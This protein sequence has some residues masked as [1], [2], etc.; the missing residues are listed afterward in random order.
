M[1]LPARATPGNHVGHYE[2]LCEVGAGGMGVV[3]KAFDH[4]LQ[5][6]VALKFLPPDPIRNPADR[7]RLLHEAR[8]A[9]TL[10]HKNIAAIHAVEEAGDGQLFIVMAYYEGMS[11]ATRMR[12]TPL[13]KA[14]SVDIV[15]QIAEGLEHAHLHNIVHRDIKPSNVI[16]TPEGEAKIVDFGLARFVSAGAS[17]ETLSLAGT[18]SY[19]SP[20]QLSG[21]PVDARTDVWSLGVIAYELLTNRMPFE[22]DNPAATITAILQSPPAEME[23]VSPELQ[24]IVLRALS[25][26]V[27]DRYQSCGELVRDLKTVDTV[28]GDPTHSV[29]REIF[30]V[31]VPLALSPPADRGPVL[32]RKRRW[33]AAIVVTLLAL[34]AGVWIGKRIIDWVKE[35]QVSGTASPAAYETY[36][37]GL[38][39]LRRYDK[40]GNLDAAIRLFETTTKADPKFALAFAALGEA[41]WD[42]Y[43]REGDPRWVELAS[44]SCRRAAELNDRLPAVFVTLGRIHDGT[45]QHNLA[46]QEFE[47]ALELDH[48][49]AD[50]LLGLGDAYSR[51]GRAQE[52]EDTYKRAA[53]MR[54]EYWDGHYRLG[55]FY[56]QQGRFPDA[57]SQFRRVVELLPDHAPAHTSL[58]TAWLSLGQ[59]RDAEAE[60]KKS[61]ALAPDYPALANLGVMYYRQKR[62]AES[63]AMTERALSLND[64]DYRLWNNLAIAYEWLGQP[65]KAKDAF[66]RELAR[67]EQIVALKSEDAEVR[68]NLG[69]MY[70]QQHQRDRALPHL[71]AAL[72]LS[73]DDPEI[74]NKVGEA[75]EKLGER[76]KGLEYFQ[77]A[78]RKGLT[79]EDMEMN[80]DLR[81]LLSDPSARRLL[82][83]ALPPTAKLQPSANR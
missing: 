63:T 34:I 72:A 65:E 49:D 26:S 66:S 7:K 13:S 37:Q 18:L 38:E 32:T 9:S 70:S 60:F 5:R 75:Y 45:G 29:G 56:Y 27:A 25:K 61:L 55:A 42:K 14:E 11:L 83:R 53:A 71:E 23:G 74:L 28:G 24:S 10:D 6:A 68:A 44:T 52:A 54:P 2:I 12:A 40:P 76:S 3:Y 50:A 16:L 78:L 17:T 73:P 30:K 77:K 19:M 15:L 67:L 35:Q 21:K 79:L 58:G 39:S 20:E 59:E 33:M 31:R 36:L 48:R 81:S 47:R 64:K 8:A 51:A 43:R 57:A 82:Q 41:Y 46:L 1:V 4:Q 22:G 69:V 62:F 80:P